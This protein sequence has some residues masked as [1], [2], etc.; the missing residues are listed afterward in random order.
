VVVDKKSI[1]DCVKNKG[2]YKPTP[3]VRITY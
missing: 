2:G 1:I 3:I